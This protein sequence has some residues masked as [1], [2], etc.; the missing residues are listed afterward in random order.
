MRRRGPAD[1]DL[2]VPVGGEDIAVVGTHGLH[3]GSE[4]TDLPVREATA[5]PPTPTPRMCPQL[6]TVSQLHPGAQLRRPLPAPAAP[7]GL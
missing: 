7:A 1:P 4:R 2:L 6:Y 3:T 5:G